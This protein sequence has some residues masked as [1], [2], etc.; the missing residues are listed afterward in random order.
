MAT[1]ATAEGGRAARAAPA[2]LPMASLNEWPYPRRAGPGDA[3]SARGAAD[4]TTHS[5]AEGSHGV[6][7]ARATRQRKHT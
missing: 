4:A 1:P 2:A 6:A 7:R 5:A 3:F